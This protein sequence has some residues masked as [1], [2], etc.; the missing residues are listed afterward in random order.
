MQWYWQLMIFMNYSTGDHEWYW[1]LMIFMNY[2]TGDH[3]C[4]RHFSNQSDI[5]INNYQVAKVVHG[6]QSTNYCNLVRYMAVHTTTKTSAVPTNSNAQLSSPV[7]HTNTHS[8]WQLT[9]THTLKPVLNWA[10]VCSLNI[11]RTLWRTMIR[12][13]IELLVRWIW[14]AQ[15]KLYFILNWLVMRCKLRSELAAD[16]MIENVG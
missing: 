12:F 6:S 3:D 7:E 11:L 13:L 8:E 1:Q 14:F 16:S 5:D 2:S 15:S 4:A 10:N 9:Y